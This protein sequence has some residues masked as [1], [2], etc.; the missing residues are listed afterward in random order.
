L[1]IA[2]AGERSGAD[3]LALGR[4]MRGDRTSAALIGPSSTEQHGDT[5][6]LPRPRAARDQ[7]TTRW[8]I[9]EAL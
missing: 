5:P 2:T 7:S 8:A 9:V 1:S 4:P 3:S 6:I